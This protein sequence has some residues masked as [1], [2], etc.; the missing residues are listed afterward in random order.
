MS[1]FLNHPV[2]LLKK[3]MKYLHKLKSE[4]K[5]PRW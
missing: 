3:N 1:D 5:I 2:T 4:T